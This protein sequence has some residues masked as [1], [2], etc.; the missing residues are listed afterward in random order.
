MMTSAT[1]LATANA[2][3]SPRP[4]RRMGL[5]VHSYWMRWR[6]K[7]S[8]VKFPAFKTVL[9]L[10]DHA[11]D[12]G[13][14]GVQA[15]VDGWDAETPA[16]VRASCE[17]YGM[18]FEGSISLPKNEGDVTRFD[19]AIRQGREA[20]AQVF[21]SAVG[22]RRYE[23][24]SSLEEFRQFKTAS[25]RSMQLAEPVARRHGVRIGIENHKD[26]HAPELVEM[27][28]KISSE[29]IGAT[30][31]TGNS[32]ALLEDAM[33]V[34][35]ALAP[36][37]VSTHIKDMAVRES[38]DGF[39]LSEVPVGE[40]MLNLDRMLQI[41]EKA[42]PRA[43]LNLEMITR[44]PLKI[45]CLTESYYA[46]FPDKPATMLGRAMLHVKKN[47]AASLPSMSERSTDAALAFEEEGVVGSLRAGVTVLGL[48]YRVNGK[49]IEERHEKE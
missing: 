29:H 20:G 13:A 15:G 33:E 26:F 35:E 28:R 43:T 10:L 18:Y 5:V 40:G 7:Y 9:D 11:R 34:V 27:L 25:F 37:V 48:D 1:A 12:I 41:I 39:L 31:D 36:H 46:T 3:V 45:P 4:G 8:S 22:G 49:Q 30:I 23:V 14:A 17:S 24:F 42:N 32:L 21:R 2:A 44:D 6:G 47:Q 16:Q 19:R 38:E